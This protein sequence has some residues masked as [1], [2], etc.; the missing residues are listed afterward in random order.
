MGGG[1]RC[2]ALE[3]GRARYLPSLIALFGECLPMIDDRLSRGLL[4]LFCGT[5]NNN[6]Q[7]IKLFSVPWGYIYLY[8]CNSCELYVIKHGKLAMLYF[9]MHIVEARIGRDETAED[10]L[11]R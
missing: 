10:E 3:C 5:E 1:G 7:Y 6:Q 8:N 2:R 11:A 4:M 9:L